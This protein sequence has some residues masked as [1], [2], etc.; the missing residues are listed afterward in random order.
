MKYFLFECKKMLKKKSI[1]FATILSIV[2]IAGFYFFNYSVAERIHQVR[3]LD[4]ENSQIDFPEKIK[5][6]RIEMEKAQE[7]GDYSK[8]EEFQ[9]MIT[10]YEN[11]IEDKKFDWDN[12]MAGNWSAI[13]EK[14]YEKLNDFVVISKSQNF[15][16]HS[17]MDQQVSMFT[18]RASAEERKLVAGIEGEPFVQ[19][20]TLTPYHPT[21][22]D[23]HDGKVLEMWEM[24]TKRYGKQGF[25]FLYQMIPAFIIPFIILIGC[26]VF[27]NNV[28][29]EAT[30]KKR[31]MNLYAVLPL[32]RRQLFFAKYFSGLLFTILFVFIVLCVPLISSLFTSGVGSLQ[33]PVLMYDGPVES[34]FGFE[35]N[36]LNEWTDE[37]HFITLGKY[38]SIVLLM[39]V[40]LVVFMFSIYYLLSL[41]IKNPTVNAA[42]LLIGTFFGMTV[43][44]KAPYNPF[45]FVDMH[46]V[47]NREFAIANFNE[48]INVGNG[49]M[50][51]GVIALVAIVLCYVRFRRYV[52]G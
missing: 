33:Y 32:K 48:A 17:I 9:R 21:M 38:F 14:Q 49:L 28:S 5:Q 27:G 44:P 47:V 30:K 24:G 51:L 35:T 22:Y 6:D 52:A 20:D 41:F 31:G 42:I 50:V 37:F 45:T 3:M 39:T 8:V 19:W 16:V 1:W 15:I 10:A 11:M 7:A 25:Y 4:L 34:I 43:L 13:S 26:F 12:I 29:S 46:R 23:S 18:M 40:V 2:A 36:I